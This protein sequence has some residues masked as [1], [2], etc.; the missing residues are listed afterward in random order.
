MG[1][2]LRSTLT[3]SFGRKV[4]ITTDLL[5]LDNVISHFHNYFAGSHPQP[6]VHS[7][8]GLLYVK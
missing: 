7:F 8:D 6:I 5:W 2:M 3:P 4:R 1:F